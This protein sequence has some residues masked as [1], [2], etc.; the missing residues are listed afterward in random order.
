MEETISKKLIEALDKLA[1]VNERTAH[2]DDRYTIKEIKLDLT[3]FI[4]C[5][6]SRLLYIEGWYSI[7][8]TTDSND[9]VKQ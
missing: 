7:F 8:H 3:Y 4:M 6:I 5:Q 1:E 9:G 2:L